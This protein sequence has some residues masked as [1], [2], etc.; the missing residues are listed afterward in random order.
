M[1]MVEH[2]PQQHP[3]S[4]WRESPHLAFDEQAQRIEGDPETP[5]DFNR[6]FSYLE[7]ITAHWLEFG[8]LEEKTAW[9]VAYE[10]SY[11]NAWHQYEVEQERKA[12]EQQAEYRAINLNQ[13]QVLSKRRLLAFEETGWA[14]TPVYQVVQHVDALIEQA[15]LAQEQLEQ[16]MAASAPEPPVVLPLSDNRAEELPF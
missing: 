7:T 15:V 13:L 11:H 8:P 12:G 5:A 6:A 16:F 10:L 9:D 14:V 3:T 1:V 2:A 4:H